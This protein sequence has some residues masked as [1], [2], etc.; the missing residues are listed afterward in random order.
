M[1]EEPV[2]TAAPADTTRWIQDPALAHKLSAAVEFLLGSAQLMLEDRYPFSAAPE[3]AASTPA[4]STAWT[5]P[6]RR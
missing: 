6:G 2:P 4:S 1:T 3:A 5:S